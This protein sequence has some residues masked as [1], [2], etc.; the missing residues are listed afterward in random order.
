MTVKLLF[1]VCTS[2]EMLSLMIKHTASMLD[3]KIALLLWVCWKVQPGWWACWLLELRR[4]PLEEEAGFLHFTLSSRGG[5]MEWLFLS[6]GAWGS[7][8]GFPFPAVSQLLYHLLTAGGSIS[9]SLA[10]CEMPVKG[11]PG[12]AAS[13]V[14]LSFL[15]PQRRWCHHIGEMGKQ[16]C[17]EI[18]LHPRILHSY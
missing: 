1:W 14:V 16:R 15:G 11:A 5:C 13:Q 2:W 17:L 7:Q 9:R 18:E 6:V 12:P 10:Q 3:K 8:Q 4:D